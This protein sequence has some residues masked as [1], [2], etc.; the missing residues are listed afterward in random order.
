MRILLRLAGLW[1]GNFIYH[2]LGRANYTAADFVASGNFVKYDI[3]RL[4]RIAYLV[5]AE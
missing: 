2:H 5:T 1:G 4:G 3:V